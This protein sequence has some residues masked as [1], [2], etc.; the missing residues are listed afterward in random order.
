MDERISILDEIAVTGL[1]DVMTAQAQMVLSA[2]TRAADPNT[3]EL[4]LS[5]DRI[6]RRAGNSLFPD[7][8]AA[9]IHQLCESGIVDKVPEGPPSTY[10][11]PGYPRL[12]GAKSEI[13]AR[14]A[15]GEQ[16]FRPVAPRR[17]NFWATLV[18]PALK[19]ANPHKT[20]RV[21]GGRNLAQIS[22]ACGAGQGTME[23]ARCGCSDW[24]CGMGCQSSASNVD[25]C[26]FGRFLGL[27]ENFKP[28]RGVLSG[29][30]G[31]S[32]HIRPC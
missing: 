11:I 30:F 8:V 25:R 21:P 18:A 31:R 32:G 14:I 5:V 28:L 9:V 2:M 16:P 22:P 19:A 4:T 20:D 23:P 24:G 27:R 17:P 10:R 26:R 1:L 29:F 6:A 3:R 13:D 12:D 7:Q 15:A